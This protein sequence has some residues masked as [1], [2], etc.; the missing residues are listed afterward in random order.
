MIQVMDSASRQ[1]ISAG[2]AESFTVPLH[3]K[4]HCVVTH[5]PATAVKL[6]GSHGK[7]QVREESTQPTMLFVQNSQGSEEG[8]TVA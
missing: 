2:E 3:R 8:A 7:Q 1:E 4:A 6:Q 5:C